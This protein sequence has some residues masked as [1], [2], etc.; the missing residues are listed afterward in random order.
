MATLLICF[1][2]FFC[3]SAFIPDNNNSNSS[4]L[5]IGDSA[6]DIELKNKRG[7]KKKLSNYEGKV[8]LVQFWAS[9]C[10]PC[11]QFSDEWINV[12]EKY[13]K[14][15]FQNGKGFEIYSVSLD[16]KKRAWKKAIKDDGIPWKANTLDNK[17]WDSD[18]A[19]IYGVNSLPAD[20]LLDGD[21]NIIAK[22]VTPYQLDALLEGM[23]K[24]KK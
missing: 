5:S 3:T 4:Y 6:P 16:K 15:K 2:A 7:F 18:Y 19:F 21:G 17:G 14:E 11:R 22:D 20:F 10:L 9:W 1:L 23:L 8:V 24:K 12:Y 13:R